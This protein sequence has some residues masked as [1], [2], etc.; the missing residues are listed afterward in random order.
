MPAKKIPK[1]SA[2]ELKAK[3][4]AEIQQIGRDE[5]DAGYDLGVPLSSATDVIIA[6]IVKKVKVVE[7]PVV[8][9][10]AAAGEGERAAGSGVA[11]E[12]SESNAQRH[13]HAPSTKVDA[14]SRLVS[15]PSTAA[16][17]L[18]QKEVKM[19]QMCN[20]RV[21]ETVLVSR[22]LTC[23][24][25]GEKELVLSV[26]FGANVTCD[27]L[28]KRLQD[29]YGGSLEVERQSAIENFRTTVRG[30]R[31]L[32]T[33]LS[34][35]Q[36]ARAQAVEHGVVPEQASE[37]DVWDLLKAAQ[38]STT[39]R[40]QVL[41][42]LELRQ[43]FAGELAGPEKFNVVKKTLKSLALS[44][45]MENGGKK[46]E[47]KSVAVLIAEGVRKGLA[48][49]GLGKGKASKKGGDAKKDMACYECGKTGHFAA[50]CWSKAKGKSKGQKGK[51]KGKG[52]K[53]WSDVTARERAGGEGATT[54]KPCWQWAE[55]GRCSHG[56]T[57]KF[58][59]EGAAGAA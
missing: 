7:V 57:C 34:V 55:K 48:A 56:D 45:E 54:K 43:D 50:G 49:K 39:E 25:D 6:A 9:R 13:G 51:G 11:E 23:L 29:R 22:L 2:E 18:W 31:S 32:Q 28:L 52:K 15:E 12:F 26:T 8:P 42:E 33:F 41:R 21:D 40:A 27:E 59:H 53:K 35:W 3:G 17:R 37:Q 4:R 1:Y 10:A 16:F 14:P 44:F 20:A 5:R 19:W 47:E 46:K 36:T 38:I 58:E 24:A 30:S